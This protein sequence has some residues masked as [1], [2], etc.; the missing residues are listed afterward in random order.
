MSS[1]CQYCVVTLALVVLGSFVGLPLHAECDLDPPLL[2]EFIV[3]A[4]YEVGKDFTVGVNY[5]YRTKDDFVWRPYGVLR[6][7]GVAR[8]SIDFG[9]GV[10]PHPGDET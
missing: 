1:R 5:T 7:I 9:H 2:N 6:P 10:S 3:G 4:E 8:T